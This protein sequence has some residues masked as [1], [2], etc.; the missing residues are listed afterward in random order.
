MDTLGTFLTCFYSH[1][2]QGDVA[3]A[4][5][6]QKFGERQVRKEIATTSSGMMALPSYCAISRK[7]VLSDMAIAL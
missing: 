1:E 2:R 4:E 3:R 7:V 5:L 6:A